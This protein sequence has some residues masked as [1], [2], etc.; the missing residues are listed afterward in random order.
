MSS[1][2]NQLFSGDASLYFYAIELKGILLKKFIFVVSTKKI[3]AQTH[4]W[5]HNVPHFLKLLF[6]RFLDE[7]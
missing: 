1:Y 4:F 2:F 5:C 6:N 7:Y 3:R